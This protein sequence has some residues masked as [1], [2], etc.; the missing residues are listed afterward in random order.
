MITPQRITLTRD[1]NAWLATFHNDAAI[2]AL[3]GTHT[4]PTPF[5]PLAAPDA[6][7]ASIQANSPDH[8]ITVTP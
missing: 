1:A 8:V 3:F 4:L 6:V 7:L 2:Y 5:T